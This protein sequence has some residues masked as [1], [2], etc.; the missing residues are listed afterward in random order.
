MKQNGFIYFKNNKYTLYSY[1][2]Y[3][4]LIKCHTARFIM[5]FFFFIFI[6]MIHF[7]SAAFPFSILKEIDN[8]NFENKYEYF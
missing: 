2:V 3:I 8:S 1:Y 4:F 6:I 5:L 7:I